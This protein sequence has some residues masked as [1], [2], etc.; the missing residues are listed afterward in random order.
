MAHGKKYDINFTANLHDTIKSATL[1]IYVEGFGG[2]STSV[3][4]T[5]EPV[6]VDWKTKND[7]FAPI[8]GSELIFNLFSTSNFEF[9]EFWT[10][11]INDVYCLLKI[12]GSDVWSGTLI[13]NVYSE[14]FDDTPYPS[15]V[16]FTDI[17]AVLKHIRFESGG[18][19]T[20]TLISGYK[21]LFEIIQTCLNIVEPKRNIVE[22]VNVWDDDMNTSNST[23]KE[24]IVDS[25]IF[26][27]QDDNGDDRG[28]MCRDVI[29]EICIAQGLEIFQSSDNKWYV[30]WLG[31]RLKSNPSYFEF[32]TSGSQVDSGS[33]SWEKTITNDLSTGLLLTEG[34]NLE[35]NDPIDSVVYH[36]DHTH[37]SVHRTQLIRDRLLPKGMKWEI[38]KHDRR[39]WD[40]SPNIENYFNTDTESV[41]EKPHPD[42]GASYLYKIKRDLLRDNNITANQDNWKLGSKPN[43]KED[44]WLNPVD[45]P[46]ASKTRTNVPVASGDNLQFYLRQWFHKKYLQDGFSWSGT[47]QCWIFMQISVG[48]YYLDGD[49]SSMSWVQ[50]SSKRFVLNPKLTRTRDTKGIELHAKH[51]DFTT[52][53][54]PETGLKDVNIRVF[55]P[56]NF[57]VRKGIHLEN[58]YI[59]AFGVE[60]LPNGDR[61]F[62]EVFKADIRDDEDV[63]PQSKDIDV[64]MGD[65][66][67][68]ISATSFRVDNSDKEITDNW[69][70]GGSGTKKPA[71]QIFLFEPIEK[72]MGDYRQI[73]EGGRLYGDVDFHNVIKMQYAELDSFMLLGMKWNVSTGERRCKL[74]EVRE[75]TGGYTEEDYEEA[76]S[77]PSTRLPESEEQELV[78]RF[79]IN[80]N[81]ADSFESG[82]Y[83][84][85]DPVKG[86]EYVYKDATDYPQGSVEASYAFQEQNKAEVLDYS[87]NKRHSSETNNIDHVSGQNGQALDLNGTDSFAK[88]GDVNDVGGA[89]KLDLAMKVNFDNFSTPVVLQKDGQY[90]VQI[91][92]NNKV[93]F[94]VWVGGQ[95]TLTSATALSTST[96]YNIICVYDGSDMYIYIDGSEDAKQA[97]TGNIDASANDFI[98]GYDGSS[99]YMD[100]KIEYAEVRANGM[101]AT[102]VTALDNQIEGVEQTV[103]SHGLEEGDLVGSG[104]HDE[105]NE[106]QM[107][108]TRKVNSDKFIANPVKGSAVD[109]N[110]LVRVGNIYR[111]DRQTG[112]RLSGRS[113]QQ[114]TDV[115]TFSDYKNTTNVAVQ[116]NRNGIELGQGE[117]KLTVISK[118]V[119][120]G[121]DVPVEVDA[122]TDLAGFDL[123]KNDSFAGN[124]NW[125]KRNSHAVDAK[126]GDISG[127]HKI[128]TAVRKSGLALDN[129]AGKRVKTIT[130]TG[131]QR[132]FAHNHYMG[133]KD[134]VRVMVWEELNS[135]EYDSHGLTNFDID[136]QDKITVDF[137]YKPSGTFHIVTVA[138]VGSGDKNNVNVA[139]VDI[140][141]D[142]STSYTLPHRLDT[143][144]VAFG[145]LK[146]VDNNETAGVPNMQT[147][148]ENEIKITYGYSFSG[149]H[150]LFLFG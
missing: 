76:T 19:N 56:M 16:R 121:T 48:D 120:T 124:F 36:Y 136:S 52:P 111:P 128:V 112:L 72:I 1:E 27:E 147:N 33:L 140:N 90:K 53:D 9:K 87:T 65:G 20:G 150:K 105:I 80:K 100:G 60:Y 139:E 115:E 94:S 14:S 144:E 119:Q 104:L 78:K 130:P 55:I 141:G 66:P 79:D 75:Y 135:G 42:S 74:Y 83:S 50:D 96:W 98:L 103:T 62:E 31:E 47:Y 132:T 108:V 146:D 44:N 69:Q 117:K 32:D 35:T 110:N 51:W 15:K 102:E 142:G 39:F 148:G 118:K 18:I 28:M 89:D 143:R 122:Y 133:T 145:V 68:R 101:T 84:V 67:A 127:T 2:S 25:R 26:R 126:L 71:H 22:V 30:V 3:K 95:K 149:N 125:Q 29:K 64:M 40:R 13:P 38:T 107:V 21:S 54:L 93:E 24:T 10:A 86:T 91:N 82:D 7:P 59:Q 6:T 113:V 73:V 129:E 137:G 57:D 99:N 109:T 81:G 37:L 49:P 46:S 23:L 77:P 123:L 12:G 114:I 88:F 43:S 63:N 116:L 4:A 11:Q 138:P 92:S 45:E 5:G 134:I 70:E 106:L 85:A 17:F 8:K 97:Q 58:W 41:R 131:V 61:N 34:A